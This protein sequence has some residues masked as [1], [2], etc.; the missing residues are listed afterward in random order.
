MIGMRFGRTVQNGQLSQV[1]TVQQLVLNI[2]PIQG[3]QIQFASMGNSDE[4]ESF[5]LGVASDVVTTLGMPKFIRDGRPS[6]A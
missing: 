2:R 1:E 3:S 4:Q 6:R 5:F